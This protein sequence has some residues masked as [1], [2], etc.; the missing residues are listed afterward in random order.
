MHTIVIV[1]N[2]N[3]DTYI[4]DCRWRAINWFLKH[5]NVNRI[6]CYDSGEYYISSHNNKLY[7]QRFSKFNQENEISNELFENCH[8]MPRTIDELQEFLKVNNEISVC[9][10]GVFKKYIFFDISYEL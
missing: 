5:Y 3:L 1:P 2:D 9:I 10:D 8:N 6:E 7:I 4:F